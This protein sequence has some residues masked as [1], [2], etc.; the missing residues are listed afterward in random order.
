MKF[1]SADD[2]N[3]MRIGFAVRCRHCGS[4]VFTWLDM[5]ALRA[6]KSLNGK[7]MEQSVFKKLAEQWQSEVPADCDEAYI[8]NTARAIHES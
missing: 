4:R 7:S 2:P 8:L 6:A 3:T 5:S 1:H